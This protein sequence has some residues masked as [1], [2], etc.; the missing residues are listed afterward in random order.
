MSTPI[1]IV[2][3][4]AA[5]EFKSDEIAVGE[6]EEGGVPVA[7]PGGTTFTP[8]VEAALPCLAEREVKDFLKKWDLEQCRSVA[9]FRFGSRF[10]P[11][12]APAFLLDLLNSP[13][14]RATFKVVSSKREP[15][16][17]AGRVRSVEFV[18]LPATILN[19]DFFDRLQ[20]ADIVTESGYIRK[21][22]DAMID[23]VT[24][25]DLLH[26]MLLNEES[27]HS[28]VYTEAE[29][30]EFLYNLFKTV[31]TGGSLCQCEDSWDAYLSTTK[32]LYKQLLSVVKNE[33]G[34]MSVSSLVYKITSIDADAALFPVESPHSVCYAVVDPL[35]RTVTLLYN[36]FIPF[37]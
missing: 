9:K 6:G 24:V 7:A 36:A 35:K 32:L 12:A 15:A 17:I 11:E 10:S 1:E 27:D 8:V 23:G 31:V 25:G 3:G 28:D 5:V 30:S 26:D 4:G 2:S 34:R 16:S 33:S 14:V 22:Y 37:W 20:S 29:K 13:D 19:M 21:C 18:R